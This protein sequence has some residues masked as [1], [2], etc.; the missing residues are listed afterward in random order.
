MLL[1]GKYKCYTNL[2]GK[3]LLLLEKYKCYTQTRRA[4]LDSVITGETQVLHTDLQ[5]RAGLYPVS[6]TPRLI[7]L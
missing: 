7:F 6:V 1:Q 2:Q 5:G 4:G 3:T